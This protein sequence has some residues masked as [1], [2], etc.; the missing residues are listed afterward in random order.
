MARQTG[1]IWHF[2]RHRDRTRVDVVQKCLATFPST[3]AFSVM[4]TDVAAEGRSPIDGF[5]FD[6]EAGRARKRL[7]AFR[8][9][10]PLMQNRLSLTPLKEENNVQAA[11]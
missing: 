11:P 10:L 9:A 1:C 6:V 2:E 8:G 7:D 5:I 3:I 4:S